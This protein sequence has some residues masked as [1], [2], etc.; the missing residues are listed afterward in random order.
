[1]DKLF[2]LTLYD[3]C[4]YLSRLGLSWSMLVKGAPY[5]VN[6]RDSKTTWFLSEAGNTCLYQ[7][8]KHT[9]KSL[10]VSQISL[11][12]ISNVCC[13]MFPPHA[14]DTNLSIPSLFHANSVNQLIGKVSNERNNDAVSLQPLLCYRERCPR[15]G[16]PDSK[17]HRAN[18]GPIWGRQ[19]PGGPH[20]GPM[21]LAIRGDSVYS[22]GCHHNISHLNLMSRDLRINCQVLIV[23]T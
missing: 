19:D 8:H 5:N 4:N 1:M 12:M 6:P 2:H 22:D 21:N 14:F 11:V 20:D 18:M 23:V 10:T 9:S 7:T 3:G 13:L 15:V 16:A 17:V